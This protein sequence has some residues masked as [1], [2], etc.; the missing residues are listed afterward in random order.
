MAKLSAYPLIGS[1][2]DA[3]IISI[4]RANGDGT[5][6]NYTVN[7]AA[8]KAAQTVS[9]LDSLTDVDLSVAATNRQALCYDL[10]TSSWKAGSL[11]PTVTTKTVSS[12][13]ALTD[14]S[15]SGQGVVRMNSATAVS[16]TVPPNSSVAFPIG[17]QIEVTQSGAG[18]VT[19][20]A[21]AGVTVNAAASL[22]STTQHQRGVLTKTDTDTWNFA[23][24]GS[25]AS[26]GGGVPN[27]GT[28]GQILV[29]QSA[30]NGDAVWSGVGN[31]T[32]GSP[33][34]G[35][36]SYWRIQY[37]SGNNGTYLSAFDIQFRQTAGVAVH[38]TGGTVLEAHTRSGFLASDAFDAND[39]TRWAL[40]DYANLSAAYLG[41]HYATP[42]SVAQVRMFVSNTETPN[43]YNIQY[44]DDG[45]TWTT[46]LAVTG[47]TNWA[48]EVLHTMPITTVYGLQVPVSGLSDAVIA[49]PAD[50]QVLTYEAATSKWKNKAATGG[51]GSGPS[52][53]TNV[54]AY[55]HAT[56][57]GAP[58]VSD[59]KNITMTRLAAGV[60]KMTFATPLAPHCI[61]TADAMFNPDAADDTGIYCSFSRNTA[62]SAD[63]S[64]V[65]SVI[66]NTR[67]HTDGS[68]L[69][70][71]N[72][73]FMMTDPTLLVGGGAAGAIVTPTYKGARA[74]K[75]ASQAIAAGSWVQLTWQQTSRDTNG[76]W[77]VANPS[78][79]TIPAGVTKIK[80][81][82]AYWT[83]DGGAG[84]FG[85]SFW[86]NGAAV[87]GSSSD[88]SSGG[89]WAF[90]SIASDVIDVVAGDYFEFVCFAT[91]GTTVF[92]G[93]DTWFAI[94]V[95][96]GAL[97]N[98]TVSGGGAASA[99]TIVQSKAFVA[100][101]GPFVL[102][103]TPT[104]G[105]FLVAF[106]SH[107]NTGI[108]FGAGWT[109]L[110][111]TAGAVTDGLVVAV[112]PV[113]SG[114]TTSQNPWSGAGGTNCCIFEIAGALNCIPF[115]PGQFKEKAG[116]TASMTVQSVKDN[117]LLIGA[118]A[119]VGNSVAPTGLSGVTGLV[120]GTAVSG[121][122]GSGGNRRVDPFSA[123]VAKGQSI[124]PT[125]TFAASQNNYGWAMVLSP[126]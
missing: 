46:A 111:N 11:L 49:S 47:Q 80:L 61:P 68:L 64:W 14:I 31:T 95:V 113:L 105:N 102:D 74:V 121:T 78:R 48:T 83:H 33:A 97:L 88:Q 2:L 39:T 79:Y 7:F 24:L 108:T 116:A 56:S 21:G 110:V 122:G 104:P 10:T 70:P 126:P 65:N 115:V 16:L 13:L 18:L 55:M 44:S 76:F 87:E 63:L 71:Q 67:R 5:F 32:G 51:S 17:A 101:D 58:V 6:T 15:T 84:G 37:V 27:G 69:D 72:L 118:F 30:T 125:I 92:G 114:D 77:N 120:A 112:R 34:A 35:A 124:V 26:S 94:E 19:L 43:S 119:C 41:Y 60:Y 29:K 75:T 38:P 99:P 52:T 22:I 57:L 85:A 36:H 107:Y 23:W 103:A 54:V 81:K 9:N 4:L 73:R 66:V 90:R 45:V 93:T 50:G 98:Q 3:D 123:V 109:A 96:E 8:T 100:A 86:K 89:N 59:S 82:G 1:I 12:I 40:D 91:G 28:V 42:V 20:A 25:A 117:S 106:G 62:Y 53:A